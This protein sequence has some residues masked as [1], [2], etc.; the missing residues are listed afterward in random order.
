MTTNLDL[1]FDAQ[2]AANASLDL[3]LDNA[4]VTHNAA[5]EAFTAAGNDPL[6]WDYWFS[7]FT[8]QLGYQTLL[9]GQKAKSEVVNA[10]REAHKPKLPP[11]PVAAS[12]SIPSPVAAVEAAPEPVVEII[13]HE[14]AATD[15]PVAVEAAPVEQAK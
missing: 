10:Q 14:F 7:I 2:K 11:V 15:A 8:H 9:R 1:Y 5:S 6:D 3:K 4:L 13:Q 12:A